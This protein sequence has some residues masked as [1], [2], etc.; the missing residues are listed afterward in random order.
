MKQLF[1]FLFLFFT[2]HQL[3][4]SARNPSENFKV[5]IALS[6]VQRDF[7]CAF[8]P[9]SITRC[10]L[11]AI[12]GQVDE[13]NGLLKTSLIR[14]ILLQIEDLM[15]HKVLLQSGTMYKHDTSYEIRRIAGDL[16]DQSKAGI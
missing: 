6:L 11:A 15:G 10:K 13:D 1:L 12:I 9:I 2:K 14:V 8:E 7:S 5:Q 16:T 4:N 3:Y